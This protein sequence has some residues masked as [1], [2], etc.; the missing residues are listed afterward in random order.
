M[1]EFQLIVMIV[2]YED[3]CACS[4][5][6][7]KYVHLVNSTEAKWKLKARPTARAVSHLAHL[8]WENVTTDVT[9]GGWMC[10]YWPRPPTSHTMYGIGD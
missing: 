10:S 4:Y 5:E 3:S 7:G 6:S 8:A 1:I 9:H 2:S